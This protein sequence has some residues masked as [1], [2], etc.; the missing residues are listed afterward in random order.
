MPHKYESGTGNLIG[1]AGLNAGIRFIMSEG[2]QKIRK[3]EEQLTD[4]MYKELSRISGVNLYGTDKAC[5]KMSVISLNIKNEKPQDIGKRLLDDFGIMTRA[6][7]HC[8]PL[9]HKTIGT[10]N[11]GT[12]RFGIGYFNTIEDIVTALEAINKIAGDL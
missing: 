3:H 6:G 7:L 2:M 8:A 12:V 10:E 4:Y 5:D 11:R 1:I 9:A